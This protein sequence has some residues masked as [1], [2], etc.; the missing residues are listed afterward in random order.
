MSHSRKS[1]LGLAAL[2]CL[3]SASP[4]LADA[5]TQAFIATTQHAIQTL[6]DMQ[7]LFVRMDQRK[8]AQA[9]GAA[10]APTPA[11]AKPEQPQK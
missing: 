9:A 1:T 11:P 2:L 8:A 3:V 10:T 6:N 5:S 4:V 7:A